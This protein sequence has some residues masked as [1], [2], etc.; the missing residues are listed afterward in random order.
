M[1]NICHQ[2]PCPS[3]CPNGDEPKPIGECPVCGDYVYEQDSV[4]INNTYVCSDCL[5][6]YCETFIDDLSDD[7]IENDL[8]FYLNYWLKNEDKDTQINILKSTYENM[9]KVYRDLNMNKFDELQAD[10]CKESDLF[11]DFIK[12]KLN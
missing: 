5:H 3:G 1:C 8:D 11:V 12:E 4:H 6:D 10:F 9:R 2:S 7:F